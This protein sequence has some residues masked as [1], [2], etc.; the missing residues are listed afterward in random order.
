MSTHTDRAGT[1]TT[2][3]AGYVLGAGTWGALLLLA[4][5]VLGP[6]TATVVAGVL[7]VTAAVGSGLMGLSRLMSGRPDRPMASWPGRVS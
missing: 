2:L 5:L 6:D 1:L 7:L 4:L 3:I